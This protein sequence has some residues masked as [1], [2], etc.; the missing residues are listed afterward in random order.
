MATPVEILD[1][2]YLPQMEAIQQ[3]I[4]TMESS[5]RYPAQ[6]VDVKRKHLERLLAK[7]QDKRAELQRLLASDA[8]V[9][10]KAALDMIETISDLEFRIPRAESPRSRIRSKQIIGVYKRSSIAHPNLLANTMK[11]FSGRVRKNLRNSA[12]LTR[13]RS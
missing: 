10:L 2:Q 6:V 5:G 11:N 12:R 7:Y 3:S 13:K 9:D 8:A 1:A 4:R